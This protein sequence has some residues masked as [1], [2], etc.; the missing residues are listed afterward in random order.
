[1]KFAWETLT[2]SVHRC[3]L[4]FLDV[5]VGLIRGSGGVMVVDTGTTLATAAALAADAVALTGFTVTHV[6][7]THHH[8]DH[9]M[10]SSAFSG[11][12][13]YSMPD[14]AAYMA[15]QR[16]HM[17]AHALEYGADVGEVDA[18]LAALRPVDHPIRDAEIDLGGRV[19]SIRHL[20]RGHTSADLAVVVP[21]VPGGPGR[22]V[23]FCGDLVEESADPFID[24]DSDLAAWPATLDR[25]LDAG[26]DDAIYVP[27][28]GALVDATFV[29]RQQAWL[30]E[31]AG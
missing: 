11:A 15:T 24:A 18:A 30:R 3:R 6:V 28:H 8:F 5:T 9:V 23:V 22:T 21:E 13:I 17:R 10:G 26:G 14:V 16:Q 27:G 29:R 12:A 20:G 2:D 1:M 7:L 25:L 31:R 4:R 19:V